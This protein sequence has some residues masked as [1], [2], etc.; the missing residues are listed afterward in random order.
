MT[1]DRFASAT[2]HERAGC[3]L[4]RALHA[5]GHAPDG[6][7]RLFTTLLGAGALAAGTPSAWAQQPTAGAEPE[8]VR[9]DVG[10]ISRATRFVSAEQVET[11]A[12]QQY[13]QMLQG[14]Q[15]QR[16]LAPMEH[17]QRQ[18]LQYIAQRIIP[19]A[20][21]W[22]PRAERW[23]WEV[24]L[25]GSNEINAFCMPGG[26]IAFYFGIL[27]RLQ[28]DDNEVAMIMGHEAAH[29]LREHARER[30]GKSMATQAGVN[31]ASALLGLGST[32]DTLLRIGGQLASLKFSR[33]DE[34]EADL[35]GLDLAARAGYDPGAGVTLW[36]KMLAASKGAPPKFLS[37]HPPG[38]SRIR[39]IQGKL[40]K[41]EP[42][43]ARARRPDRRFAAPAPAPAPGSATAR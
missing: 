10:R 37:T 4:C 26:K 35:V 29:A 22:N 36:Q 23:K 13:A 27:S 3:R 18:R 25:L 30:I 2:V 20:G 7:R 34:T 6:G 9:G 16:A 15:Q 32:G 33:D 5:A 43:Y 39:D 31:I 42:L 19:F 40:P 12:A 41:V 21:P 11:A 17:P 28:L 38:E 8:G 1:S 14:A 24:N